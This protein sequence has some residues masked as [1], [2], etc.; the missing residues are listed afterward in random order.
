[1]SRK[2][3]NKRDLINNE[4]GL[5][6]VEQPQ[7]LVAYDDVDGMKKKVVVDGEKR[8]RFLMLD[9]SSMSAIRHVTESLS[10]ENRE[11]YLSFSWCTIGRWAW[12]AI[13]CAS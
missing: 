1:M 10:D 12:E 5:I 11:K 2:Y 3:D 7:G 13:G 6:Y 8:D 4:T 9:A